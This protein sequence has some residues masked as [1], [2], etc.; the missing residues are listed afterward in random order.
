MSSLDQLNPMQ[1]EAVACT[2]GPLL[3][4]AGAGSGKTR[5]LAHRIAYLIEEKKVNPWNILA[6]TFT[7]KAAGEMRERVDRQ[8]SFGAESI[9][10]ST[11]HA[12]CARILRRHIE[13]LG[14]T[15]HFTIYD[16]DDQKSLLKQVYKA[17]DI[18][19]RLYKERMVLGRIS[20]A[21]DK[22]I[23][24]EQF[25]TDAGAD[26]HE[27]RIGEIYAEYQ[28]RLKK[29]D[30]LDFDDLLM[31][32]VE[33]F[34]TQPMVLDYYQERF[35]YILIDE[36]QDTNKAQFE[37]VRLLADKYKNICVVGDDDQSIY[38]FRG[39]DIGNIL[40]FEEAFPGAAVVKLEQNYRSTQTI[41]D[42]ANAVIRNNVGRKEKSL[43]TANGTG[44]KIIYK[45]FDQAYEEADFIIRD[46][47]NHGYPY[48]DCA[49]LYRTN[50]QSRLLEEK[51]IACSVPY[52]LV[53]GVNF[54][55]RKEIKDM[56]A[57]LKTVAN[58]R[59]DV[60]A[61][62]IINVPKRGI[63]QASLGK[64][65]VFA[66][67]NDY[68]LYDAMTRARGIPGLGKAA[69]KIGRFTDLIESFRARV[70]RMQADAA[71]TR[72]AG[73]PE[74]AGSAAGIRVR[75]TAGVDG[76]GLSDEMEAE[77]R[78]AQKMRAGNAGSTGQNNSDECV[79]SIRQLIE[80]ILDETGYREEL[81]EEGT[82]EADSRLENIEELV[83]KAVDY[84]RE[85]ENP[86]LDGFLEEV[87]LVADVDELDQ[88][89]RRV[90]LMTLHSAK[91]LEF[92]N[93]YLSGMEDGVFPSYMTV[94]SD[95]PSELEEERRLCYVGITRAKR[96]LTLTGARLRMVNGQTRYSKPSCFLDE[97]P[98]ELVEG[99]L[100]SWSG[101][102]GYGSGG[103]GN[104]DS[105]G[106]H[107]SSLSFERGY[108]GYNDTDGEPVRWMDDIPEQ[109][110]LPWNKAARPEFSGNRD[111]HTGGLSPRTARRDKPAGTS[112][113]APDSKP[114][115]GRSFTVQKSNTCLYKV[116]DRVKHVKF[117]EGTVTA[118]EERPKDYM[119][120]VDFDS[121][122]VRRLFASFLKSQ[123][124]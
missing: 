104:R 3:I 43:W 122:G 33:L 117:G 32:T 44:E 116:G 2:E 10:V 50:A 82:E 55:Q 5:V 93:V 14:Y 41:L 111:S 56:L 100:E 18:D 19:N 45:Q 73:V 90:T 110:G 87:A 66:S 58:G 107:D 96:H 98:E 27:R 113:F 62:R 94:T 92:E 86:T 8:V 42:A 25:I 70:R 88:S 75:E 24:P 30:A 22:L 46:I 57:Y 123:E 83:N 48:E 91:G 61:A 72:D 17:M 115:F 7:N 51:C 52:R 16:T 11:F 89:E 26:Y 28:T 49:V 60:A 63:G 71:D 21:K 69:E 103:M 54:Y 74:S 109:Q 15:T 105:Y 118:I 13:F 23:T 29:N 34:M 6:I 38:K 39:A 106:A 85:A 4:L 65:T 114:D 31:K 78:N 1:K 112:R 121:V 37:L 9:W 108:K 97:I 64:V 99:G 101:F 76:F 120:A 67:A 59:D 124:A 80:D 95:D 102:G 68:T 12:A 47:L 84:E 77:G 40:N 36:Y 53:G 81:A 119:V 35:K 79:Y 20:S